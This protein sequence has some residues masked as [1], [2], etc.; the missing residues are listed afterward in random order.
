MWFVATATLA[1]AAQ[2]AALASAAT[3]D[4]EPHS[5]RSDACALLGRRP[6]NMHL[7]AGAG[8]RLKAI[9]ILL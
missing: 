3:V 1:A 2:A 4:S 5:K 9:P 6:A 8:P 7:A